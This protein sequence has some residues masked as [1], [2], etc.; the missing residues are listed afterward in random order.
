MPFAALAPLLALLDVPLEGERTIFRAVNQVMTARDN[1]RLVVVV[2]DAHE[3]DDA[4]VALLDQMVDT[5]A[6]FVILTVRLGA[7]SVA[8]TL[9]M[10]K[11]LRV[12]R[13]QVDPLPPAAMREIAA[14]K[15]G[16][17]VEAATLRQ[18]VNAS[19]G[20]VL[21]LRELI[22][23]ALESGVLKLRYGMWRLEG[24]AGLLGPSA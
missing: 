17:P 10:W 9:D 11:D 15:L 21:F 20:N 19:A 13:V 6:I 22:Q 1:E 8:G 14:Q 23:G 3:L 4:S 2:D 16:G 24:L 12:M 5:E 7:P 18:L